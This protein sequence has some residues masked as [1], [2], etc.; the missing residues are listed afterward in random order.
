MFQVLGFTGVGSTRSFRRFQRQK[1]RVFVNEIDNIGALIIRIGFW[2]PFYH[3][4][5][6]DPPPKKTVWVIMKASMYIRFS[7]PVLPKLEAP[8]PL[9]DILDPTQ[10]RSLTALQPNKP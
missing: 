4:Y 9:Q 5:N 3:N 10:I 1:V 8:S 2:G 7:F 6:M